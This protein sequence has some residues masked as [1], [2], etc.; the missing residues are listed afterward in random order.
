[1]TRWEGLDLIVCF[2][3]DIGGAD[4]VRLAFGWVYFCEVLRGESGVVST[5]DGA[6]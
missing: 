1:M 6:T 3:C 5:G 4:C 2:E